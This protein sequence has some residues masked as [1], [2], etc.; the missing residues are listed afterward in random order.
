MKTVS[1][2]RKRHR[3]GGRWHGENLLLP[4]VAFLQA[5]T[6]TRSLVTGFFPTRTQGGMSTQ[7]IGAE[8]H[9]NELYAPVITTKTSVFKSP[10]LCWAWKGMSGWAVAQAYKVLG[11]SWNHQETNAQQN[12]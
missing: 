1:S 6:D 12:K 10:Q 3:T 2:Q 4:A 11:L 5:L 8:E 7:F 9:S